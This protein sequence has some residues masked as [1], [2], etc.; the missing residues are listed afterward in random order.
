LNGLVTEGR[1]GNRKIF[2]GQCKGGSIVEA[3][4]PVDPQIV[5]LWHELQIKFPN[6]RNIR[7]IQIEHEELGISYIDIVKTM[8]IQ[9]I[10]PSTDMPCQKITGREF[11]RQ[12]TFGING[13]FRSVG[14]NRQ[15][16]V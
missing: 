13:L 11:A 5:F 8:P 6:Q 10:R 12:I 1:N 4:I 9:V 3:V 2:P 14:G 15:G 16:G 7:K